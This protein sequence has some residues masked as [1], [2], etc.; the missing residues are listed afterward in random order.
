MRYSVRYRSSGF[1]SSGWM[2]PVIKWRLITNTADFIL[3]FLSY[4]TAFGVIFDYFKLYPKMVVGSLAIWQPFSYLFLHGGL[5]HLFFNMIAL[6]M[7]GAELERTWG[8][9]RFLQFYFLCGVGAGVCVV[10]ADIA[11]GS[12]NIPTIGASGAIFGVL[13]A[14]GLLFPNNLI[15]VWFLFPI[16]AKYFVLALGAINFLYLIKEPGS[17]VSHIAHL[18]GM[19]IGYLYLRSG[20]RRIDVFA[21]LRRQHQE[22][23][24]QRA[25]RKFKVYLR[26]KNSDHDH[27]VH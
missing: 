14:F 21:A 3:Y 1:P 22:W 2:T 26:K 16:K 6:W 7:F 10:I 13:L 25:K 4:G 9:Q 12:P 23:K 17:G 15:W 19:L 27:W 8:T 5:W 11:T 20:Y 18:G 24:L